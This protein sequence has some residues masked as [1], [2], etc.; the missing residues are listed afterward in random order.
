MG[1]TK[2]CNKI[3]ENKKRSLFNVV[4]HLAAAV[5]IAA[6]SGECRICA[7][8]GCAR[9]PASAY[10]LLLIDAQA[11]AN[12][13][14]PRAQAQHAQLCVQ[15]FSSTIDAQQQ[16][17][18]RLIPFFPSSVTSTS[19]SGCLK[20]K[21]NAQIFVS[22]MTSVCVAFFALVRLQLFPR[23]APAYANVRRH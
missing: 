14:I 5:E 6:K 9:A 12:V 13:S 8:Y 18:S 19:A 11:D 17:I 4:S 3:N 7:A 2:T 10:A 21:K 16:K 22:K 1:N 15:I 20:P 23:R